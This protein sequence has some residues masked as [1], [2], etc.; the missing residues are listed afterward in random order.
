MTHP[1]TSSGSRSDRPWWRHPAAVAVTAALVAGAAAG[2]VAVYLGRNGDDV[3]AGGDRTPSATSTSPT[4]TPSEPATSAPAAVEVSV[5][6]RMD[7]GELGPRL[8]REV[9][10]VAAAADGLAAAAVAEL[11]DGR[12][13]DPDY[14][15]SWPDGTRLLGY[16]VDGDVAVVDVSAFTTDGAGEEGIA[17]QQLVHTVTEN[18]NAVSAVHLLVDGSPPESEFDWSDPVPRPDPIDILG[19]IQVLTPEQ[20][21]EITSPVRFTGYGTAF[22]GTISYEV[23]I[24]GSQDHAQLVGTVQGGSNG[25]FAEF[26]DTVDLEPGDY[27]LLVFESSA[28][29]GRPL[30]LDSKTFTV[31]G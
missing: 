26:T 21:A 24:V 20:G 19:L 3:V 1:E 10:E 17:V 25:E 6:Y 27:E 23:R 28:E 14:G 15:T 22:E 29:D 2:A 30:H 5:F 4:P 11:L 18:D 9:H 8:Y 13:D 16:D 7:D 12:P 31:T